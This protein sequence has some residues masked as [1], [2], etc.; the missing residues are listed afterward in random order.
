MAQKQPRAEPAQD[1]GPSNA[2]L[3]DLE[4]QHKAQQRALKEQMEREE[5]VMRNRVETQR[6]VQAPPDQPETS[7]KQKPKA[8]KP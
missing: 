8:N 5:R 2:S 6:T 4:N 7:S 3:Q 1:G